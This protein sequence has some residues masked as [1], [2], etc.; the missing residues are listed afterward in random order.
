MVIDPAD[1]NL[2][3]RHSAQIVQRLAL[4]QQSKEAGDVDQ[5]DL[6]EQTNLNKSSKNN[7][8]KQNFSA[9]KTSIKTYAEPLFWPKIKKISEKLTKN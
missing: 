4:L 6:A 2:L 9:S 8:W 1:Q 7:S 5:V 3:G